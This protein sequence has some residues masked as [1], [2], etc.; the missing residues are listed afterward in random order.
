MARLKLNNVTNGKTLEV[1]VEEFITFCKVKK[2]SD[3]TIQ[4]YNLWCK[5]FTLFLKDVGVQQVK[6][7]SQSH[8]NS[9]CINLQARLQ[10]AS[11]NTGLRHCRAILNYWNSLGYLPKV[12]ITLLKVQETVKDCYSNTE[13]SIL[14][15]KPDTKTCKFA[16]YRNWVIVNVLT[17]TGLR[18]N[19][20]LNLSKQDVDFENGFLKVQITKQRKAQLLPLPKQLLTILKQYIKAVP[21]DIDLLFPSELGKK[22]LTTTLYHSMET[23]NKARGIMKVGLHRYRHTFCRN[24]LLNGGNVLYL[25]KL[26]GH[27]QLTMSQK[28]ANIYSSDL[29]NTLECNI[30]NQLVSGEERIKMQSRK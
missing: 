23:Y 16:D 21:S 3:K 29:Q 6:D 19:S 17:A 14:L 20:I 1:G 13:L 12:K 2:L 28:Y 22:M 9:Y 26:L 27:S 24:Y 10:D 5:D 7:I 8:M 4:N 11:V 25:Q 18:A 15:K 30:Y